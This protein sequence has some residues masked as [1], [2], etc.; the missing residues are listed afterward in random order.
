MAHS[1][2]GS[3]HNND[4]ADRWFTIGLLAFKGKI[5]SKDYPGSD[6]HHAVGIAAFGF[7]I[8]FADGLQSQTWDW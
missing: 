8:L 4:I 7:G 2:T 3:Y 6:Y 5:D 1:E